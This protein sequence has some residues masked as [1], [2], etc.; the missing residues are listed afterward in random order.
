MATVDLA[1]DLPYA[2]SIDSGD[3]IERRFLELLQRETQNAWAALLQTPAGRLIAWSI[4][5]DCHVFSSTYTGN[6]AQAFLE[7]ERNVGLKILNGQILP[8]GPHL[9]AEMMTEADHRYERLMAVAQGQTE[10]DTDD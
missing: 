9:L 6:A 7:G 1:H 3:A 2:A 10:G 8:N 4:L 5:A